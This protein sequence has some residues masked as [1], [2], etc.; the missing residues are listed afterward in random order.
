MEKLTFCFV[1][2]ENL[3]FSFD[4]SDAAEIEISLE[5]L[6]EGAG[7]SFPTSSG[8]IYTPPGTVLWALVEG[9]Q[10]KED[11]QLVDVDDDFEIFD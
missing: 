4:P 9:F 3:T 5:A 11:E 6:Q 8:I 1:N 2:G 10:R 7:S